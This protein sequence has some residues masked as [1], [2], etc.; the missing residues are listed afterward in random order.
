MSLGAICSRIQEASGLTVAQVVSVKGWTPLD[1]PKEYAFLSSKEANWDSSARVEGSWGIKGL[2]EKIR[3][4]MELIGM[5]DYPAML[6]H[7]FHINMHSK[8]IP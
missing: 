1:I 4:I 5:L 3:S 8:P 6:L 7:E 2:R